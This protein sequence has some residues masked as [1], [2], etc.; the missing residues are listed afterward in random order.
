MLNSEQVV[1]A[2]QAINKELGPSVIGGANFLGWKEL[3][4]KGLVHQRVVA[5]IK[6]RVLKAV[7]KKIEVEQ[8]VSDEF[9]RV[10][11]TVLASRLKNDKG[12]ASA[13]EQSIRC[14]L[15]DEIQ[16]MIEDYLH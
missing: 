9:D 4:L 13:I 7:Y 11:T 3:F 2:R 15:E 5:T 8:V 10:F 16:L 14:D 1:L 12:I 6:E